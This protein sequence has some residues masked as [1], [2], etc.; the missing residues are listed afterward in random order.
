MTSW[1]PPGASTGTWKHYKIAVPTGQT[2][3]AIVMSGGT[4][5]ADLYVKRGSQ[6]TSTSYDYRPYLSGNNETVNVTNPASGDWYISIYAYSTYASVSLKA[7]YSA[8]S[9]GASPSVSGS[10]LKH[11]SRIHSTPR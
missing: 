6:P 1:N 8:R 2:S 4:G 3:L 10:W 7:T 5:D 11:S 9:G